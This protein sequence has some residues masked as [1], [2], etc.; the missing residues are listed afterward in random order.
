MITEIK[1]CIKTRQITKRNGVLTREVS[2]K[3]PVEKKKKAF[4]ETRKREK[5]RGLC[6]VRVSIRNK[7][8]CE[9]SGCTHRELNSADVS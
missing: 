2:G 9:M 1:V 5:D 7:N 4:E 3:I 6:Y 8:L